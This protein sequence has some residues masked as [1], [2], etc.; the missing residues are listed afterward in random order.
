MVT[1][2]PAKPP[3][4]AL[5]WEPVLAMVRSHMKNLLFRCPLIPSRLWFFSEQL[6]PYGV[7][8]C[9]TN[10]EEVLCLSADHSGSRYNR[11]NRNAA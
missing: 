7:P 2:Y 9:V 8:G 10:I 4:S 1:P 3:P 6:T 5:R 11:S